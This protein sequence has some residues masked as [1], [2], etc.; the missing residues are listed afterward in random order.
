MLLRG[1]GFQSLE[2]LRKGLQIISQPDTS[3]PGWRN[4]H[5]PLGKFVGYPDLAQSW[6]LHRQ[7]YNHLLDMFFNPVLD[8]GLAPTDLLQRQL[9]ALVVHLLEA[10]EAVPRVP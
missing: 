4:H 1:L 7:F 3:N 6:L 10:V 9:T 5:A 2:P 8:A